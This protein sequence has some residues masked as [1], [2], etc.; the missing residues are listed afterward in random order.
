MYGDVAIPYDDF[1]FENGGKALRC[2]GFTNQSTI[3]NEH[4]EGKSIWMVVPQKGMDVSTKRF[5]A[6]L[7]AMKNANLAIIARYTYRIGTAPK[8]M[9]L[10]P[11]EDSM[12]MHELFFKDNIVSIKLPS[13]MS[14]KYTP[15]EE[16]LE[17]MDKFIDAMDLSSSNHPLHGRLNNLMDPGVQHAYR[18]I[19]YRAINPSDPIPAIDDDLKSLLTPPKLPN[20]DY[21]QMKKLFPV[22]QVKLT[23]REKLLQN[24]Q[25]IDK[26]VIDENDL[27]ANIQAKNDSEIIEIGTIRPHEDFLYLLNRGERFSVLAIQLQTVIVNL[28]TKV[29][30]TVLSTDDKIYQALLTYR[31]TAKLKGP[32]QYNDWIVTLKELLID[33]EKTALWE[34]VVTE[35]LGLITKDESDISTVTNEEAAAFYKSDEFCTQAKR[36]TDMD[37]GEG[38]DLFDEL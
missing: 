24:I 22:E 1:T 18:V 23:T 29:M 6:L 8:L 31:E 2:I 7:Q 26:D 12:L 30:V 35:N 34:L 16:Q 32:Y 3:L 38:A 25:N 36:A 15:N 37:I 27:L 11:H 17:L 20:V 13:L 28:V 14:K 19:A 9:A 10:F 5:S 4:L 21:D 33:S